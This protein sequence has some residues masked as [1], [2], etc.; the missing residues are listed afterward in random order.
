MKYIKTLLAMLTLATVTSA[1]AS[2]AKTFAELDVDQNGYI[3]L[4]EASADPVIAG[5]FPGLDADGD[6]QLSEAEFNNA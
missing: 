5:K 1:M 4:Q 3:S 2:E 6:G